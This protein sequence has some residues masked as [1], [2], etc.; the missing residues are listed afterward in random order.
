MR[1]VLLCFFDHLSRLC[2]E[3]WS[4]VVVNWVATYITFALIWVTATDTTDATH[5]THATNKQQPT[6]QEK[7]QTFITSKLPSTNN[8][9]HHHNTNIQCTS[10]ALLPAQASAQKNQFR[11]G[12][13]HCRPCSFQQIHHPF[14]VAGKPAI[15]NREKVVGYCKSSRPTSKW[16]TKRVN[17]ETLNGT[18]G[19][20]YMYRQQHLLCRRLTN[21]TRVRPCNVLPSTTTSQWPA[22]FGTAPAS[23][24]RGSWRARF[25]WGPRCWL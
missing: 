10:I 19:E 23:C 16:N 18:S 1:S 9:H 12:Q 15:K 22:Q 8:H 4:S 13:F 3:F 6:G 25:Q 2:C 7:T 20:S 21:R 17:R 14:V 11:G 5:A 24:S